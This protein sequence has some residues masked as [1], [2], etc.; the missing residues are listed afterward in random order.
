MTFLKML[1][2]LPPIFK[3]FIGGDEL[4][5]SN[6]TSIV[7]IGYQHPMVLTML[8][9][10]AL[11]PTTGLL[12]AEAERGT[13]E[14]ILARPITR[15]RVYALVAGIT[16][17]G[18]IGLVGV[19][20]LGTAIWTRVFNYGEMI[21]LIG[22]FHVALNLAALA[23]A[24][25][26]LSLLAAVV[27]NERAKAIGVVVVYFVGSYLLDFSVVWLPSLEALHPWTLFSYCVPNGV[28]SAG[29]FPWRNVAVLL[30][31]AGV[32][33]IVGWLVWRKRDLYAA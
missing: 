17:V 27:F 14:H 4:M 23:W 33:S 32:S 6:V 30:T 5:P 3:S 15:T 1:D 13:M 2:A 25:A 16:F 10:N 24:A 20:F 8:M 29:V 18:Q 11:T 19:L 21:P 22:F 28:L 12:T 9:I 26:G 7:A 31:I